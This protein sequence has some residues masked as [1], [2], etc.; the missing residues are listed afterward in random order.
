M[1][2][3]L[4]TV[5]LGHRLGYC[6]SPR[7]ALSPSL[8]VK[9]AAVIIRDLSLQTQFLSSGGETQSVV[10]DNNQKVTGATL[11]LLFAPHLAMPLVFLHQIPI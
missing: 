5:P 7:H 10:H 6:P 3:V 2:G 8:K 4:R 9:V 11:D 1:P